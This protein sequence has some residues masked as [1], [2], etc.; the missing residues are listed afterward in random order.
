MHN[1][2][3]CERDFEALALVF[4]IVA[5]HRRRQS[6]K[7]TNSRPR[8]ARESDAGI[9][10]VFVAEVV[11]GEERSV[12]QRRKKMRNV[13]REFHHVFVLGHRG[14]FH[15]SL[16]QHLRSLHKSTLAQIRSV[17]RAKRLQQV[18]TEGNHSTLQNVLASSPVGTSTEQTRRLDLG[19]FAR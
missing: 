9:R 6:V 19:D 16:H 17:Q 13:G 4:P 15:K 12:F 2:P 8:G 5:S 11:N 18:V 1:A 10:R 3:P 14:A 7:Q